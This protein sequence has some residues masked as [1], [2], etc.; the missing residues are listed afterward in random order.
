MVNIMS[1]N[2]TGR[3]TTFWGIKR[4]VTTRESGRKAQNLLY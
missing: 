3:V 1:V 2:G 4:E